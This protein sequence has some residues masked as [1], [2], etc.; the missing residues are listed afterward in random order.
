MDDTKFSTWHNVVQ[1][2][3][4][5]IIKR[6]DKAIGITRCDNPEYLRKMKSIMQDNLKFSCHPANNNKLSKWRLDFVLT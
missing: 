2:S 5:V 1:R 4:D 3:R 6:L